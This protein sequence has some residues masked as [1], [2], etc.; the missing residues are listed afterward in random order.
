VDLEAGL[1]VDASDGVAARVDR[2]PSLQGRDGLVDREG[3]VLRELSRWRSAPSSQ[4]SIM[5][6]GSR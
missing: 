4:T 5:R 2:R 1:V 3:I 6:P